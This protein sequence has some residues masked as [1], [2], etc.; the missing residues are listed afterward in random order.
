MTALTRD[1]GRPASVE[2]PVMKKVLLSLAVAALLAVPAAAQKKPAP[3]PTLP[4]QP[5]PGAADSAST[6]GESGASQERK[7]QMPN[8]YDEA[9][10]AKEEVATAIG[11]AK[12]EH[13]RV[14][15]VLGAN[16]CGWCRALDRL[17]VLDEKV[18][19]LVNRSYVLVKVDVGRMTKNLDLAASWGADPKKGIP[20][21]VILDGAG[22]VVKVQPT[23]A[24]E[25]G[26]K[27]DRAK[28]MAFLKEHVGA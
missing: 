16:W 18:A 5:G 9:A 3:R 12:D 28:V 7:L 14:L 6:A 4:S 11:W 1:G 2:W 13:K 19:A 25:S 23:D 10:N 8:V 21:I 24:L 27:Y 17:F 15:V 20:L 22:K 26:K